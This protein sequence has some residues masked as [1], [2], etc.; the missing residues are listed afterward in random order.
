MNTANEIQEDPRSKRDQLLTEMAMDAVHEINAMALVA[1]M[2]S[3]TWTPR[4]YEPRPARGPSP[5]AVW[6]DEQT[7]VPVTRPD[8]DPFKVWSADDPLLMPKGWLR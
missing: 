8:P 2:I 7:A 5:S 6:L 1:K 4:P 3:A